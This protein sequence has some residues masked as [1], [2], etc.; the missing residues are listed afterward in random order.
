MSRIVCWFSCG[1]ASAVATKMAIEFNAKSENPKE[2]VVASIFLEDEH[3]DSARFLKECERWF[4]KKIHVLQNEKYK[5]SVDNVIATTRYMSGVGGARCTKELKKQ[6]RLDWQRHDDIHVF[7]MTVD[8]QKRIDNLIDNENDLRVWPVLVENGVTKTECFEVVEGA[9]IKLPKMY[10]LG[11][12]NNNCLGCLKAT[13]VGYWNKIR[14]DFPDVF[15]K[16]AE[17][18][19]LLGVSLCRM[20]ANKFINEYPDSFALMYSDFIEKKCSIKIN[21]NGSMFIPLRYLPP[22]A[23]KHESLYVPDCGF[24]CESEKV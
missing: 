19:R 10:E 15:L 16:R 17:Q 20:S 18:E 6:V 9:G 8:E 1:A 7:G 3:P 24:F 23:G 2:I 21:S 13:S 12:N 4:G 14:V 22:S 5:A 11:Y